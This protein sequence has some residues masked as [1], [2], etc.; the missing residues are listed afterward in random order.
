M[1][2]LWCSTSVHCSRAP[3]AKESETQAFAGT[4]KIDCYGD[5][6]EVPAYSDRLQNYECY[7]TATAYATAGAV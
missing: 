3:H 2:I 1:S 5:K 6:V 7:R 4:L